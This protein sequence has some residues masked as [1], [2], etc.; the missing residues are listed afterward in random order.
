MFTWRVVAMVA[1]CGAVGAVARVLLTQTM[2]RWFGAGFP[3]G[4]LSVNLIGCCLLGA[5]IQFSEAA[6]PLGPEWRTALHAGFFGGLTTF[7]TF[8]YETFAH[9]E[10][11]NTTAAAA[12]VLANLTLGLCAV[13]MGVQIGRLAAG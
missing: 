9:W 2:T 6:H 10:S 11:G 5:S 4:T 7:S 13:W 12:N 3:W 8:G 1:L